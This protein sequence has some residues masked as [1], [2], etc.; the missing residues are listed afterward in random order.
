[1]EGKNLVRIPTLP[2]IPGPQPSIYSNPLDQCR[3]L[4]APVVYL[5]Q[6]RVPLEKGTTCV[7]ASD[8]LRPEKP[9]HLDVE[10]Y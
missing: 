9:I 1:M 7:R 5:D 6:I 2:R 8:Q 10:Y 3:A 4:F